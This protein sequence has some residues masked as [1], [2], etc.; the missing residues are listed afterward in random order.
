[1][2]ATLGRHVN[3]NAVLPSRR[4][5]GSMSN[6][7]VRDWQSTTPTGSPGRAPRSACG[8]TTSRSGSRTRWPRQIDPRAFRNVLGPVL[9]RHHD[10]HHDGPRG[11]PGRLRLSVVRRTVAGTAAGAVLPDQSVT[12]LGPIEASGRLLRQHPARD[13]E[14]RL[15]A[16]QFPRA[17]QSSPIDWDPSGTRV[18]GDQGRTRPSTA[19]CTPCTTAATTSR[20]FRCGALFRN[21]PNVKPRPLLFLPRRVHRHRTDKEQSCA[22]APTIRGV[23]DRHLWLFRHLAQPTVQILAVVT[24]VFLRCATM[25]VVAQG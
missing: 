7:A 9:H 14:G 22:M 2:S 15:G 24:C 16:F 1:M 12:V 8:A 21:S 17:R 5:A 13:P 25:Q 23:S 10:H 19:R 20:G 18:A 3:D 4:R 6:S 11:Q